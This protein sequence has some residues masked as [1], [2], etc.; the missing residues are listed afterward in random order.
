MVIQTSPG[1]AVTEYDLTT[2]T[3]AVSTS[4]GAV[5]GTFNWGPVLFPIQLNSE[6]QLNKQFG[7][8]DQN[9]AISFFTAANFLGYSSSC[10]ISRAD[11]LN[12][13]NA[14]ANGFGSVVN[15]ETTYFNGPY[16]T[17]V[18][19]NPFTARYPG[20]L[21]NSLQVYVWANAAVWTANSS[22]SAD[23]LYTYANYFPFA[24]NTTPFVQNSA[25]GAVTGDA[26]HVL[27]VD[28]GGLFTG[29]AN[30]VLETYTGLSRLTDALNAYG[31]S[32]YYKN[33]LY[34]DSAY[35]YVTGVPSANIVGWGTT[36]M[37]LPTFTSDANANVSI[38]AGGADGTIADSN[39]LNALNQFQHKEQVPMSLLM[40]GAAD[41]IVQSAAFELAAQRT[42]CVAF[43][44]PPLSAVQSVTPGPAAAIISYLANSSPFYTSYGVF[45]SGWKYQYDKYNDVF[46][47]IPLNGDIAGLCA[48]TDQLR[49]PWWSPA[50]LQRG[51]IQNVVKLAYNPPKSDRNTLYSAGVNPV[52]SF[53]GEGTVLYGDKTFLNYASAFDRIN[54]RRLFIFLEQTI[55]LAART[56]LFEFNDTFTRAAFVNLVTPVLRTVQGQRG[57]TAFDVVCDGTNNTPTVIDAN[58]FVGDIYIQP[59]RSINF[60]QLNFIAVDTGVSFS[61][62]VGTF[63]GQ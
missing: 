43:A 25:N 59:A 52:V 38:L 48:Q 57:I 46:R 62:V 49:A 54:V 22:N 47:Y 7:D 41:A 14:T 56:Q 27:V 23:P 21:G 58:Q 60:I 4:I 9:S 42:D 51:Q 55:S 34:N 3:T 1:V 33:V 61:T 8:P 37:S 17:S 12:Q 18:T 10:W 24:P 53:P 40:T 63:G 31:Q 29:I 11:G 30:S 13:L 45:D 2:S 5:F 32:N 6:V 39:T 35:V 16:L 20:A 28:R 44:S 19:G 15:N 36:T 26:L 50:G